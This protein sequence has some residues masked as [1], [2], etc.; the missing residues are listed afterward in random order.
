MVSVPKLSF[1]QTEARARI[2]GITQRACAVA[3]TAVDNAISALCDPSPASFRA[4]SE[5]EKQLDALDQE[6][7][8]KIAA[9]LT[10][11][12]ETEARELLCCLKFMIYLERIG[13]LLWSF[14]GRVRGIGTQIPTEDMKDLTWMASTL[15]KMLLEVYQA[16]SLQDLDRAIWVLRADSEIDR[17]RN[18]IFIRHLENQGGVAGNHSAHVLLMAQ[19]IERA[20]DHAKNVAEE[21]C[22]LLS[23]HTMRHLLRNYDKPDEE[24]YLE[25]LR[26]GTRSP[27]KQ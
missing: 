6:L 20:G 13:D 7:D 12:S 22:H 25:H 17:R 8:E 24:R 3:Q 9:A 4:V 16:F 18:L 21:V 14:V 19:A 15:Q 10:Q 27:L 23:G 5:C 26:R 1:P 2:I 11:V